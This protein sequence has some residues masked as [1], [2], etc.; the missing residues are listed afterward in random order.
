MDDSAGADDPELFGFIPGV[1]CNTQLSEYAVTWSVEVSD[2]VGTKTLPGSVFSSGSR[3]KM[4]DV[5]WPHVSFTICDSSH[6]RQ[7]FNI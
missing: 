3:V 1:V 6:C 4:L 2:G 5:F 7:F